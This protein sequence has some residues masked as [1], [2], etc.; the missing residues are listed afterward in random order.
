MILEQP[1]Q[2]RLSEDAVHRDIEIGEQQP[3]ELQPRL[4]DNVTAFGR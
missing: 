2:K 4:I 3:G 1:W